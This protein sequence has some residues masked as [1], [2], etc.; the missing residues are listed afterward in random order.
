MGLFVSLEPET[1]NLILAGVSLEWNKKIQL[2]A[3][4]PFVS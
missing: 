3:L 1:A 4:K 2:T